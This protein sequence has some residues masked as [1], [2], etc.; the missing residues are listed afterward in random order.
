MPTIEELQI[1]ITA[2]T[3]GYA[4][5]FNEALGVISQFTGEGEGKLKM[6]DSAMAKV[7]DTIGVLP[8]KLAMLGPQFAALN[9]IFD[10]F[11]GNLGKYAK[12][13]GAE[14]EY[15]QLDANIKDIA[16]AL[17]E[18]LGA[19]YDH[20]T[21]KVNMAKDALDASGQSLNSMSY[22]IPEAKDALKGL[23][24]VAEGVSFAFR[25]VRDPETQS[26]AWLEKFIASSQR[27]IDA[28]EREIAGIKAHGEALLEF[29]QIEACRGAARHHRGA[30]RT[31][32]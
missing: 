3:E 13:L 11:M 17:S 12:M 1:K 14:D 16:S 19:A 27:G 30:R 32:G 31:G 15:N 6:L 7:G 23:A 24:F 28:R 21:G 25:A 4:G 18:G 5:K 10:A 26:T 22:G 2:D 9:L 20:L 8:G 29:S